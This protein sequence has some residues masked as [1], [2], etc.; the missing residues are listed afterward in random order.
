MG[1]QFLST[2]WLKG[3]HPIEEFSASP[4]RPLLGIGCPTK[5]I[6]QLGG[7]FNLYFPRQCGN[8]QIQQVKVSSLFPKQCDNTKG[9][10]DSSCGRVFDRGAPSACPANSLLF[11]VHNRL[12]KSSKCISTAQAYRICLSRAGAF[13]HCAL[14]F[15]WSKV[16]FLWQVRLS[17]VGASLEQKLHFG[18]MM[19]FYLLWTLL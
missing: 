13:F 17:E 16:A 14:V 1:A 11:A 18:I 7:R 5:N 8:A 4:V 3:P 15:S 6:Q 10:Y 2:A 9:S 12:S 19:L